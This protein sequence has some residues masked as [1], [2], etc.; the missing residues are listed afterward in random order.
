MCDTLFD[1]D[2]TDNDW[3]ECEGCRQWYHIACAGL[4][5]LSEEELEVLSFNCDLC[6]Y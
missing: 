1:T 5:S 3:V 2:E 4:D 6:S